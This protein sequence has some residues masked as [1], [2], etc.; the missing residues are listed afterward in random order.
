MDTK[1]ASEQLAAR[2]EEFHTDKGP[3]DVTRRRTS[4]IRGNV[5]LAGKNYT[6]TYARF[7]AELQ[8]QPITLLEIGIAAGGST[9]LWESFFSEATLHAIDISPSC[10]QFATDRTSVHIGSQTDPEFLNS[11]TA[12]TGPLDVV[13]DDGGHTM[14]QHRVSL[15]TLWPHV[16]PGGLYIIEDLHTAYIEKFGG[17]GPDS[18]MERLKAHV[19]WMNSGGERGAEIAP[20]VDSV[21]FARS[22][23]VL[24]KGS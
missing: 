5:H 10:R 13:I 7:F 8:D 18:T 16:R 17:G 9:K 14:E 15:E 24:T 21:F 12:S 3:A 23:A 22:I 11:V 20:G 1:A 4:W 6:Q 2:A 19:D